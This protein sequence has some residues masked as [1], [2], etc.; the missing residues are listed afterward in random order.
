[1][2]RAASASSFPMT[3]ASPPKRSIVPATGLALSVAGLGFSIYLTVAHY[4]S[5]S[6]LACSGSGV[7][8]CAKVTT[9][10]ESMIAGVPVALL[11]IVFFVAMIGLNLPAAW[12][13]ARPSVWRGRLVLA[14]VGMAMVLWFVY[15]E[16]FRIGSICTYCTVVHVLTFGLF[17]LVVFNPRPQESAGRRDS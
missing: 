14:S 4:T 9:S 15:A 1:M 17:V 5:P 12:R 8:D 6:V 2:R 13:S 11:G 16:L 3:A 10:Q 7:V